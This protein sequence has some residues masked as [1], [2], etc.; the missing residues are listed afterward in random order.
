MVPVAAFVVR[1]ALKKLQHHRKMV[2]VEVFV[3]KAA[4]KKPPPHH[5]QSILQS[6]RPLVTVI[7]PKRLKPVEKPHSFTV[8]WAQKHAQYHSVENQPLLKTNQQHRPN[9]IK[10]KITPF[11]NYIIGTKTR[12]TYARDTDSKPIVTMIAT[13]IISLLF[14]EMHNFATILYAGR[15][16]NMMVVNILTRTRTTTTTATYK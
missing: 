11:A 10:N 2:P 3:V 8:Y 5:N 6:S 4:L 13:N 12:S 14:H 1:A 7:I 16:L 15:E 9:P